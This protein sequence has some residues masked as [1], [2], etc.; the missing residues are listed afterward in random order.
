M[1][2]LFIYLLQT[3]QLAGKDVKGIFKTLKTDGEEY[4]AVAHKLN[5]HFKPK[6]NVTHK[7]HDFK[8]A[9]QDKDEI[10]LNFV[11]QLRSLAK[12]RSFLN[13]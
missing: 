10:I 8:Q 1:N 4:N 11:T 7:R 2:L 6:V 9:K 5:N 13:I 12:M 3:L